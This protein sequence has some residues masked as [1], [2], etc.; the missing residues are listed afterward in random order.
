MQ[1]W[2]GFSR[3]IGVQRRGAVE[4]VRIRIG[5]ELHSPRRAH[6]ATEL[7]RALFKPRPLGAGGR[8]LRL[9]A[10]AP[11]AHVEL[12]VDT[13][14]LSARPHALQA[15]VRAEPALPAILISSLVAILPTR[16][17]ASC[18]H[19]MAHAGVV[20]VRAFGVRTSACPSLGRADVHAQVYSTASGA[21]LCASAV[22]PIVITFR[23]VFAHGTRPAPLHAR[24]AHTAY[25]H[26][27]RTRSNQCAAG[28]G[29][30]VGLRH[31]RR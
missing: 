9:A 13:S 5:S 25:A 16:A 28:V 31:C 4:C 21:L 20:A 23:S 24:A 26:A 8:E 6:S 10:F 12:E 30:S 19:C 17:A 3:R 29:R 7:V 11:R 14:L 22:V 2:R 15:L 27:V 18:A 1:A